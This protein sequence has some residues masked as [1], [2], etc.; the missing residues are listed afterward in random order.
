[1]AMSSA[2]P[3]PGKTAWADIS[4]PRA[5]DREWKSSDGD[6]KA[7]VASQQSRKYVFT[8]LG[9]WSLIAR[10]SS[11][12]SSSGIGG[13]AIKRSRASTT[14]R[15]TRLPSVP[16]SFEGDNPA[17]HAKARKSV[18]VK[19]RLSASCARCSWYCVSAPVG[20]STRL[21][22]NQSS[23]SSNRLLRLRYLA[24]R[25]SGVLLIVTAPAPSVAA[26]GQTVEPLSP[27]NVWPI[28]NP[29]TIGVR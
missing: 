12:R 14:I 20:T 26:A 21:G 3:Q 17:G 27:T 29:R 7:L 6:S 4:R 25:S 10:N 19:S 18:Y 1:M 5:K 9:A 13:E 11:V 24:S 22:G 2:T 16:G 23:A 28:V 8:G 15:S